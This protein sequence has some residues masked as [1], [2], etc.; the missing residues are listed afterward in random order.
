M[1]YEIA[2]RKFRNHY[3]RVHP[4]LQKLFAKEFKARRDNKNVGLL[5]ISGLQ[6]AGIR[7]HRRIPAGCV[8]MERD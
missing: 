2:L 8:F 6:Q 4:L 7:Y 1:K 5:T 3:G